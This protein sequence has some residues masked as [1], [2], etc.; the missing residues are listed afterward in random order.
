M[1]A[2]LRER[3]LIALGGIDVDSHEF[4]REREWGI[5]PELGLAELGSHGDHDVALR[6]E[7]LRRA[8]PD[9]GP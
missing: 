4:A 6:E 3:V 8:K 2:T 5:P 1:I 9:R 7:A